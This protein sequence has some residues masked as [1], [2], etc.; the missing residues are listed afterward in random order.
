MDGMKGLGVAGGPSGCFTLYG[1]KR[2]RKLFSSVNT[3]NRGLLHKHWLSLPLTPCLSP[4]FSMLE[5]LRAPAGH[6]HQTTHCLD[7]SIR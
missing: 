1:R 5:E 4:G 3:L 2:E 7:R 6:P